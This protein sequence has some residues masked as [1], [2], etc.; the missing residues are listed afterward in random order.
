MKDNLNILSNIEDLL[1]S[2]EPTSGSLFIKYCK[3][4]PAK[5]GL[6]ASLAKKNC[7]KCNN[8]VCSNI[9]SC[10]WGISVWKTS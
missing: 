4:I 5:A 6:V 3:T 1:M 7:G 8:A 9:K 10:K 2:D